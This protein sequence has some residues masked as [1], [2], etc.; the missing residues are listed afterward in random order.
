MRAFWLIGILVVSHEP[1]ALCDEAVSASGIWLEAKEQTA[2]EA[3]QND[4]CLGHF[5]F[6]IKRDG[7]FIAGPSTLGRKKE[8]RIK[9]H[10]LQRLRE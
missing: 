9:P 3:M 5:G 6:T 2:C 1:S 10:E 7:A 4:Y 8:G